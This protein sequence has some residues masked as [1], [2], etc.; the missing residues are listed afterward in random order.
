VSPVKYELGILYSRRRLS[1]TLAGLPTVIRNE[2]LLEGSTERV[3]RGAWCVVRQRMSTVSKDSPVP[4]IG[5][6]EIE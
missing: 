2:G 1:L 3:V 6:S 5:A 4:M